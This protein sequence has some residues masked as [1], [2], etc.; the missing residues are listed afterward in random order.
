MP[1]GRLRALPEIGV[2]PLSLRCSKPNKFGGLRVAGSKLDAGGIAGFDGWS[3]ASSGATALATRAAILIYD[4][5]LDAYPGSFDEL[6]N[7]ARALV[8]KALLAHRTSYHS[9]ART[10]VENI[11]GPADAHQHQ[12]RRANVQRLFGL[13]SPLVDEVISCLES[14]ATLWGVGSV[15]ADDAAEFNFPLP[16]SLSGR[17][18]L[19]RFSA[20]VAW[21]SP[22]STGMRS[23]K[24]VRLIV[25]EPEGETSILTKAVAGQP[26]AREAARGTLFHRAWEG[27]QAR[28]FAEH[29]NL[30]IPV[31]RMPD[32]GQDDPELVTFGIAV[33]LETEAADIPIYEQVKER[34]R[35]KPRVRVPAPVRAGE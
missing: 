23:Y 28:L 1:G 29:S 30:V 21:F 9:E 14:R 2:S 27:R 31:A 12:K 18:C 11:F 5:L 34:L 26:D 33:T 32:T 20:T 3:G 10:L 19:R 7:E 16:A 24:S 15:G 17:R 8:V 25:Q 6:T 13:G 4:A 22:I 35:V